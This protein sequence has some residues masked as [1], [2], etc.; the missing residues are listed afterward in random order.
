[1]MFLF[2]CLFIYLFCFLGP[3]PQHIEVP[4]LGVKSELLLLAYAMATAMLDLSCICDLHHSSW[5]RRIPDPGIKHASSWILVRLV[6]ATPQQ[7]LLCSLISF[8]CLLYLSHP[9]EKISSTFISF[10]LKKFPLSSSVSLKV[11]SVCL[12]APVF[13]LASLHF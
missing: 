3:H 13:P 6:S 10:K 5:Q 1:M 12:F 9:L 2:I 4:R 11:L 8:A 7:Q